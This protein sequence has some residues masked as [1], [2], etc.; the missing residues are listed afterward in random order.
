MS[1]THEQV[2]KVWRLT[3]PYFRSR[4]KSV[5][6]FGLFGTHAIGEGWIGCG[7]LAAIIAAQC[8]QI[9][10]TVYFN[11]WNALFFNA[12]QNK[13]LPAFWQ[14]LAIFA[15]IAA[16]FM[17]VA[18]YQL[19]FNQWLQIRWRRWMTERFVDRWL[20][21]GLHYRMGLGVG[22]AENLE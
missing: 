3:V 14:Q 21:D 4:E 17:I 12:I 19:Y 20:D 2:S 18:V 9:C 7:L 6:H 16:A 15:A 22:T 13:D 1:I 8:G 11:Q 10:L 5:V